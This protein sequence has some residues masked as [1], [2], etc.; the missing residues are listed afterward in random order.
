MSKITPAL[1]T[2]ISRRDLPLRIVVWSKILGVTGAVILVTSLSSSHQLLH[3]IGA[4]A[5]IYGM[6]W[7]CAAYEIK[8][9]GARKYAHFLMRDIWLSL[10]WAFLMLIWLVTDIL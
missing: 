2:S 7:L 1:F 4:S 9:N 6:I 5:C 3:L 10:A 8:R